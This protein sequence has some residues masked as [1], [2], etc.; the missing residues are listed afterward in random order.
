MQEDLGSFGKK[1]SAYSGSVGSLS[2]RAPRLRDVKGKGN[3][4][5][6]ASL[7]LVEKK[8]GWE[9][10]HLWG[11]SRGCWR[12]IN[13]RCQAGRWVASVGSESPGDT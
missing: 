10:W 8:Q 3:A 12:S 5:Q 4:S 1:A 2:H 13:R 6:A 11:S 7:A 9:S